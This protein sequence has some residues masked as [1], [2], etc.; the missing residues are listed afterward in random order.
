MVS[1]FC[2]RWPSVEQF[3]ERSNTR[4]LVV[5]W[6]KDFVAASAFP[7]Q[8]IVILYTFWNALQFWSDGALHRLTRVAPLAFSN[9]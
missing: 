7:Q 6:V 2:K 8:G 5:S 9:A 1:D 3:C 4:R